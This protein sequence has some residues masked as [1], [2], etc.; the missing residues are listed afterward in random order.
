MMDEFK[1][2]I[3][4]DD[5]FYTEYPY[6]TSRIR[7]A[8]IM[9]ITS[10][11]RNYDLFR[12]MTHKDQINIIVAIEKSCFNYAVRQINNRN[13]IPTWKSPE[14]TDIYNSI[15][16][17]LTESL[18][19]K[20][21]LKSDSTVERIVEKSIDLALISYMTDVELCPMNNIEIK[22]KVESR[23]KQNI[24]IKTTS[25]YTCDKCGEDQ[26]MINRMQLRGQDEGTSTQCL[27]GYCG[28]RWTLL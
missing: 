22:L 1:Y 12:D 7:R 23:W 11:L 4:L 16:Y 2:S 25:I 5:I 19:C 10:S 28:H 26:I 8:K 15:C 3:P 9:L 20:S 13:F 27:C 21:N 6:K 17:K 18:D 14:M 24:D